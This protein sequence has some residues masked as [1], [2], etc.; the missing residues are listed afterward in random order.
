MSPA[1]FFSKNIDVMND[2]KS[3]ESI[4]VQELS[5]KFVINITKNSIYNAH[6]CGE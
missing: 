3:K 2:H 5:Y 6:L 4:M 1:Q